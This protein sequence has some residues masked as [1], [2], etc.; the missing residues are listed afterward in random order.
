MV[1]QSRFGDE[2]WLQPCL[3]DYV[4]ALSATHARVRVIAA[5]F[6]ADC[7]ETLEEIT[8]RLGEDFERAGGTELV[9][10]PCLNDDAAWVETLAIFVERS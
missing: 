3:D 4:P 2:P 9:V 5:S 1:F 8:L 6:T 7:L 10:V